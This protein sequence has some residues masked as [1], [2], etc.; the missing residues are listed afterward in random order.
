MRWPHG[1]ETLTSRIIRRAP[2][3]GGTVKALGCRR[4]PEGRRVGPRRRRYNEIAV[5]FQASSTSPPRP[6]TPPPPH[7]QI[8]DLVAPDSRGKL[9]TVDR[10]AISATR[11]AGRPGPQPPHPGFN[12][13]RRIQSS[14]G[15][16]HGPD[17]SRVPTS[18]KPAPVPTTITSTPASSHLPDDESSSTAK[19][20]TLRYATYQLETAKADCKRPSRPPS[21]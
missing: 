17:H 3:V 18:Q 5:R 12:E 4:P 8:L 21:P 20:K 11:S 1:A 10:A 14:P 13:R 9:L 7:P 2:V 15:E 16:T 6:W 19:R